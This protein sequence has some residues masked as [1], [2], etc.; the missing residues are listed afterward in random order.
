VANTTPFKVG[1]YMRIKRIILIIIVCLL[2]LPINVFAIPYGKTG[3]EGY[4]D[5]NVGISS[6]SNYYINGV[7]ITSDDLSDVASIAMLDENETVTGTWKMKDFLYISRT[8]DSNWGGDLYFKRERDGDPTKNVFDDDELGRITF[9]GWHTDYEVSGAVIKAFADGDPGADDMPGRLEFLTTPDGSDT[10]VLRMA[11]DNAG[12]IK[13]GDGVWTNFINV[14]AG[15]VLTFEGTASITPKYTVTTKTDTATLTVAEA[16]VVNVSAAA[17]Y[18]LTL[19][20]ASGNTG[21]TYHFI[22]TDANYNLITLDGDG[23]ETLNYENSTG[24][25]VQTYAR[26]NTYCAE[27]TVV[28]DG[29]NWQVIDEALGQVPKVSVYLGT[30]QSSPTADIYATVNMDTEN[31][32]I[33]SNYD[34]SVWDSGNATDTSANHLVAAGGAFV[35]GMVGYLVKNTTDTTYAYITVVNS[36]T[37]V[38]IDKDIFVDGEGYEI[39]NSRFVAPIPGDYMIINSLMWNTNADHKKIVTQIAINGTQRAFGRLE[40]AGTEIQGANV[41]NRFA[42]SKDDYVQ[43]MAYTNNADTANLVAGETYCFGNIY[44]I[45]KE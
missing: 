20:T 1:D 19:P 12:N 4:F 10:P 44:L 30:N 11:I 9:T 7:Q 45:E 31:Y 40:T 24:A 14:S 43:L 32:D 18:T 23:T 3:A 37:D 16:G 28:S 22:K 6:G 13:M 36:A 17:A 29:T 8:S 25:P 15:G 35:A 2:L 5:G 33:G 38:T 26:L 41:M 21:L 34:T 42:L 39:K 27:V